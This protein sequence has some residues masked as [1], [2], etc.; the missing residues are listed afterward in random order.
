MNVHAPRISA[1]PV[2]C[3]LDG[4]V[5]VV[6][7]V[8]LRSAETGERKTLSPEEARNT[9]KITWGILETEKALCRATLQVASGRE[10]N[11]ARRRLLALERVQVSLGDYIMERFEVSVPASLE[12][13]QTKKA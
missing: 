2:A 1:I 5:H 10:Y 3:Y 12:T 6:E 11:D 13:V 9:R 4:E 8:G 7:Q